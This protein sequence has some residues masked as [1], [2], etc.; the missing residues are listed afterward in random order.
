MSNNRDT[1]L[2]EIPNTTI[3]NNKKFTLLGL[4]GS[5]SVLFVSFYKKESSWVFY[6]GMQNP[7]MVEY[8]NNSTTLANKVK[9][10]PICCIIYKFDQSNENTPMAKVIEVYNQLAYDSDDSMEIG[11]R[12][13]PDDDDD[14]NVSYSTNIKESILKK[15]SSTKKK[16]AQKSTQAKSNRLTKKQTQLD[17]V[18]KQIPKT[19]EFSSSKKKRTLNSMK[20]KQR[21]ILPGMPHEKPSCK[22]N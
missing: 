19:L 5:N 10:Y 11:P 22:K 1:K 2:D 15:L 17:E 16:V 7:M 9:R 3:L 13:D 18:A 21:E 20:R 14:S 12:T 4:I 8:S 6:D